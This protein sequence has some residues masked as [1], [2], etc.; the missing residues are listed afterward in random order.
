MSSIFYNTVQSIYPV[1]SHHQIEKLKHESA[2]LGSDAS[3]HFAR[4][5]CLMPN[6][7]SLY[8]WSVKL[9]D[10]F[11]STMASDASTSKVYLKRFKLNRLVSIYF[12]IV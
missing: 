11:Y 6:L 10:E 7:R 1:L 2:D 3:S 12:W 9:S 4:G 8:L 5:L